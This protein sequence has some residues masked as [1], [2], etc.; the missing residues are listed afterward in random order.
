[1]EDN[2]NVEVEQLNME[3]LNEVAGGGNGDDESKYQR[4]HSLSELES[5]RCFSEQMD[6]LRKYKAQKN[7]RRDDYTLS[8][9]VSGIGRAYG[10][11]I[12]D[13]VIRQ[14]IDKY[15]DQV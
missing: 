13:S 15:W 12:D 6:K 8:R 10:M 14:F 9:H 5:S 3:D 7:G 4:I 1:M 11:I 2:M